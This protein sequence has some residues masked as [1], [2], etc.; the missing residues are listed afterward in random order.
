[1]SVDVARLC[2]AHLGFELV[3]EVWIIELNKAKEEGSFVGDAVVLGDFFLHILFQ[4]G[5]I[6]EE[7]ASE[8]SQELEEQLNLGVIAPVKSNDKE[9]LHQ[10]F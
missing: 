9:T 10:H 1:M 5:H 6:A 8:G 7:A 4:E 2:A 3:V